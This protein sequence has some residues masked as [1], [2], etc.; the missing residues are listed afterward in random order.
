MSERDFGGKGDNSSL[1]SLT[2]GGVRD[3][4]TVVWK[5]FVWNSELDESL[6]SM[7]PPEDYLVEEKPDVVVNIV[8]ATNLERNLYLTVQ[9]IELGANVVLS[10]K[11]DLDEISGKSKSMFMITATGTAVIAKNL[12]KDKKTGI[13]IENI[14]NASIEKICREIKWQNKCL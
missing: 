3:N 4:K 7:E 14:E 9:L 13:H 10:M 1:L 11:V 12:I 8:D 6:F 5:D 2:S